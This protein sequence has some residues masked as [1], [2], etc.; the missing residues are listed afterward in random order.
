MHTYYKLHEVY[1]ILSLVRLS[2]LNAASYG[3][4]LIS[5]D[6]NDPR[7]NIR[8]RKI[9]RLWWTRNIENLVHQLSM[10][11]DQVDNSFTFEIICFV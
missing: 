5:S 4:Y 2:D 8:H 1:S 9:R 3:K 11:N 10:E 7:K 6:L